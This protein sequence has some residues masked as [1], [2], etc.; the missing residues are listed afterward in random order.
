L[1]WSNS[2]AIE[3]QLILHIAV[4]EHNTLLVSTLENSVKIYSLEEKTYVD[5]KLNISFVYALPPA[6]VSPCLSCR[7]H[8]V[9]TQKLAALIAE[10]FLPLSEMNG[11]DQAGANFDALK[12]QFSLAQLFSNNWFEK[13]DGEEKSSGNAEKPTKKKRKKRVGGKASNIGNKT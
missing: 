1:Y 3:T 13:K 9:A 10:Y 7:N 4:F 8:S 2:L 6:I 5:Y 12:R 11:A